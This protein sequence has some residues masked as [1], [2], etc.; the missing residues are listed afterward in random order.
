MAGQIEN[1]G[2]LVW[3]ILKGRPEPEKKKLCQIPDQMNQFKFSALLFILAFAFANCRNHDANGAVTRSE[4]RDILKTAHP[5][6]AGECAPY[7]D[8]AV[9]AI[10]NEVIEANRPLRIDSFH[11]LHAFPKERFEIKGLKKI[12]L[13]TV[14]KYQDINNPLTKE[15][16]ALLG[17]T[18]Y[19]SELTYADR[20]RM[21]LFYNKSMESH[22]GN[23]IALVTIA[24]HS[25]EINQLTLAQEYLSE[26]YEYVIQSE[27]VGENEIHLSKTEYFGIANSRAEVDSVRVT[28]YIYQVSKNGRIVKAK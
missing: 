18:D 6:W 14:A 23:S 11:D 13:A 25:N 1:A 12:G 3:I 8:S 7:S 5:E 26:G 10:V 2:A 20:F 28:R 15:Q 24:S 21:Y 9:Q 27:L 4:G 16:Q 17:V 19:L 22:Y